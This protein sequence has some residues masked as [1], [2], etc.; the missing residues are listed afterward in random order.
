[1]TAQP[2]VEP[3]LRPA[4]S[5]LEE[6]LDPLRGP[7]EDPDVSEIACNGPG[8]IWV[9]RAGEVG[10]TH[11]AVP[12]LTTQRI[13]RLGRQVAGASDQAV[14]REQPLLSAALPSGERIQFVLPPACVGGAFSI[15]KQ[16]V[17]DLALEELGA[18]GFFAAAHG[19]RP[20]SAAEDDQLCALLE[21]GDWARLLGEAVRLRRNILISGGTSTAKTTLLNALAKR[22][23]LRER[24]VTIEDTRELR[25][26]QPNH[27]ALLASRGDQGEARVD[28]QGLLD[29]T[30]RL[31]PDRIL[32]GEIRGSEA[33][34][35]LD[36]ISSGHRGSLSTI[37]ADSPEL[38]LERLAVMVMRAG[39]G[40][41]KEE[42]LGHVRAVVDLV[43]QLERTE[44]GRRR[45]AE[46]RLWSAQRGSEGHTA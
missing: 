29:A 22:I 13:V 26:A 34:T 38:A 37:H 40:L 10:M 35:F 32:L 25:L 23:P 18:L 5:F 46:V 4:R 39:L 30:L 16:V 21:K 3:P 11:H 31:R 1:V 27:V 44:D 36:A 19:G 41:G 42:I 20:R 8:A 17:R 7:L 15:R 33:R 12:E 24:I 14:S 9:E 45:I 43:V 2:A 28:M 6:F